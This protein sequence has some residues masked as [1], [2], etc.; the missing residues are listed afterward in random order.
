MQGERALT[1]ADARIEE[2]GWYTFRFIFS[3]VAGEVWVDFELAERSGVTLA[4]VENLAPVDMAGPYKL[5]FD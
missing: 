3:D 4:V 2:A 5:P 1:V